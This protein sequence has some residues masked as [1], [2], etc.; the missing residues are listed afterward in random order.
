SRSQS[1]QTLPS[2][3]ELKSQ[4]RQSQL[5]QQQQHS[6]YPYMPPGSEREPPTAVEKDDHD[7][8]GL[9]APAFYRDPLADEVREL[10]AR[11]RKT[12][13]RAD[14]GRPMDDSDMSN[15]SHADILASSTV[16]GGDSTMTVGKGEDPHAEDSKEEQEEKQVKPRNPL[17][18]PL[19]G[20]EATDITFLGGRGRP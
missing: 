12:S 10:Y 13:P 2:E 1:R 5:S 19:L 4:K 15:D 3:E 8:P 20:E 14:I 17:L 16:Y 18:D 6:Q 9:N 7:P 11:V